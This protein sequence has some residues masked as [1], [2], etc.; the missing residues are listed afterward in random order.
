MTSRESNV[1]DG[2]A[3]NIGPISNY[4]PNKGT[5][6]IVSTPIGNPDDI[7]LRAINVLRSVQ[8]V[9]AEDI[10]VVG[11]LLARLDIEAEVHSLRR[12]KNGPAVF[13]SLKSALITGDSIAVV[14][15]AGTPLIADPGGWIVQSAIEMQCRV[16]PVPGAVAAIAA[17]SV[18][19]LN[20]QRFVFDGFPPRARS[21][22]FNFFTALAAETRTIVLYET[23]RF[24]PNTLKNL[25]KCLGDNRQA[26]VMRDMTRSTESIHRGRLSDMLEDFGSAPP[27]G[28]YVLVIE[29]LKAT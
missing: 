4:S 29:G 3:R 11:S 15:D 17:L 24:L 9:A 6:Y 22:R 5:V 23:T 7:T 1:V 12:H 2:D 16:V 20:T 10:R 8:V 14:C 27:R 21:D 26:A 28:E 13:E 25:A 19:G 18:S